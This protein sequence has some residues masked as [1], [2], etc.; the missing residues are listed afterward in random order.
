MTDEELYY[1]GRSKRES[2]VAAAICFLVCVALLA[3]YGLYRLGEWA[4]S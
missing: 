3:L 2:M 4:L 1:N